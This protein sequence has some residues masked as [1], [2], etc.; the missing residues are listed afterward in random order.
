ME[1]IVHL[2][3]FENEWD[4]EKVE[5]EGRGAL[6]LGEAGGSGVQDIGGGVGRVTLGHSWE[7]N[8]HHMAT[9]FPCTPPSVQRKVFMARRL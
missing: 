3:S 8:T 4:R 7:N 1:E 6:L 5:G 9:L 2:F